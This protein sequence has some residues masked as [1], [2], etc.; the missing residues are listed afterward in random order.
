MLFG[1][2]RGSLGTSNMSAVLEPYAIFHVLDPR[3]GDLEIGPRKSEE[4]VRFWK[5][6]G[7]NFG[8]FSLQKRV[9]KSARTNK[10]KKV[11]KHVDIL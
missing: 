2:F 1:V 10:S 9:Q 5:D 11:R 8:H 3:K 6:F 4:K 7:L